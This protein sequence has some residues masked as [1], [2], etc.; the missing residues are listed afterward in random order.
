MP[1][2]VIECKSYADLP[3]ASILAGDSVSLLDKWLSELSYDCDPEDVGIL[4][5]KTNRKPWL[6]AFPIM[7]QDNFQLTGYTIYGQY[8]ITGLENF[9]MV[10]HQSL[11]KICALIVRTMGNEFI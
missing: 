3:Y 6:I 4:C 10:N 1:R 9:L 11:K 2:L 5:F 8:V 7:Y